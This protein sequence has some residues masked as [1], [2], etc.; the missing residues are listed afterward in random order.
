[1]NLLNNIQKVKNL[2]NEH[3]LHIDFAHLKLNLLKK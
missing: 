2:N 3:L 1:M